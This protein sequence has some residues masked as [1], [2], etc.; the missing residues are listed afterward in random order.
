MGLKM[1]AEQFDM[2]IK[3][4]VYVS[5]EETDIVCAVN[6]GAEKIQTLK[7]LTGREL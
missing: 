7:P 2:Q 1:S 3:N 6:T 4:L 5:N